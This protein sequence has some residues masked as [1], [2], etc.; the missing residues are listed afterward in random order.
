MLTELCRSQL[1]DRN[2]DFPFHNEMTEDFDCNVAMC[3]EAVQLALGDKLTSHQVRVL[4]EDLTGGTGNVLARRVFR[5]LGMTAGR[6][7]VV[8]HDAPTG[9]IKDLLANKWFV[10]GYVMYGAL[11]QAQPDLICDDYK[12]A[13]AV[14]LGDLWRKNGRKTHMYDPLADGRFSA[15]LGRKVAQGVQTWP[16]WA[17]RD[18]LWAYSARYEGG[19]GLVSGYA[20][21][22][23]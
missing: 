6:D 18:A 17:V 12:D 21:K 7:F 20:V 14:G 11:A 2:N 16:W 13:H 4:G 1:N 15:G 19:T 5:K 3:S 23:R 9:T 22:P 8:F 10:V